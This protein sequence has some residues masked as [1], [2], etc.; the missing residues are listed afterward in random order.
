MQ[1][2]PVKVCSQCA[3]ANPVGMRF[4]GSCGCPLADP[5]PQCGFENPPEFKFCGQC[6]SPLARDSAL[7]GADRSSSYPSARSSVTPLPP[8]GLRDVAER[9]QLTVV[10]CDLVGSV[11]LSEAVDAE[12]LREI[13]RAYQK[14]V[15]EVVEQHEGHIAQFLGDGILVYFGY[16]TA[17]EDDAA[18][19]VRAGLRSIEEVRRLNEEGRVSTPIEI[20]VG[21]HTGVGVIG[22]VGGA[23]KHEQL[24]IGNAPNIAARVQ[25]AAEPGQVLISG[26]TLKIVDGLFEFDARR[27]VTLKGVSKPM[28]VGAVRSESGLRRRFD[29]EAKRGLRPLVGRD[30]ELRQLEDR[31]ASARSGQGGTVLLTGEAGLGKSRL[32]HGFAM[33]HKDDVIELTAQCSAYSQNSALFPLVEMYRQLLGLNQDASD[34]HRLRHRLAHD[35]VTDPTAFSLLAEFLSVQRSDTDPEPALSPLKRR[36]RTLGLLSQVLLTRAAQ[37]PV[38]V[39]IEDLHWVDPSTLEFIESLME[40]GADTSLLMLLSARPSFTAP[41]GFRPYLTQIKLERLSAETAGRIVDAVAGGKSVPAEVRKQLLAKADGV[42]LYIEEMTKAVIESGILRETNRG[43]ELNLPSTLRDSLV[44][45]LDHLGEAKIVAQLAAVIGRSFSYGILSAISNLE[46]RFLRRHLD[47]LIQAELIELDAS[48]AHESYTFRHALIRD[49][50]YDSLLRKQREALHQ[51]VA[52]TLRTNAADEITERPELLAWHLEGAGLLDEAAEAWT[53]AGQRAQER[54]ANREAVA[55]FSRAV[56]LLTKQPE[57][58]SRD[59]KELGVQIA[60][61]AAYIATDG[62][63]SEGVRTAFGRAGDLCRI[64]GHT[65]PVF[66]ALWGLWS[67]HLVA[68]HHK[69]SKELAQELRQIAEPTKDPKLI[70]PMSH[71]CGYAA[72]FNA[73]YRTALEAANRG[74]ALFDL[75]REGELCLM[76]QQSNTI[77]LYDI[78]STSSWMLGYPDQAKKMALEGEALSAKLQHPHA[79]AFY[80][81]SLL[82]GVA[83]V[84]RDADWIARAVDELL[85]IS[86]EIDNVF[87]P[88][89]ARVIGGWANV[90]TGHLDAVSEVQDN[91]QTWHAMGTGV[92]STTCYSLLMQAYLVSGRHEEGFQIAAKAK[93]HVAQWEEHHFESEIYRIEAELLAA[94]AKSKQSDEDLDLALQRADHAVSLARACEARSMELRAATTRARLYQG[95][96]RHQ[97]ALKELRELYDGFNEGLDTP[98]LKDARKLLGA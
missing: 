14:V 54:A 74:I 1:T 69:A 38:I 18:R 87:W 49:A 8:S 47:H 64:M 78:F 53:N 92:L 5:C 70:V 83:L 77:A 96:A 32:L 31:L 73:D 60:L 27:E 68:G 11:R 67:Y 29:V 16:P 97:E 93:Q 50:A 80:Y 10:F 35:G 3:A 72:L 40:L 75:E 79:S 45:R 88:P 66:P 6:A 2:E 71:A 44:A 91:L 86:S 30:K 41:W 17:H 9:R 22:E 15:S 95:H 89:F 4:C 13:V 23:T 28:Q 7:P 76:Y 20:R 90:M 94:V 37:Q 57:S 24:V 55:H 48:A 39:T 21:I 34:T 61:G 42:P 43:Y 52:D 62:W 81:A 36:D 33:A 65:Q 26:E 46:G 85:K 59:Q 51:Q 63:A 19:A 84:R 56:A 98:D 12:E 25:G 82:W 58:L